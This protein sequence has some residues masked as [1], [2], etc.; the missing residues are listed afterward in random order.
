M[1]LQTTSKPGHRRPHRTTKMK[2]Q[3]AIQ[4]PKLALENAAPGTQ[5][6]DLVL[7]SHFAC[8]DCGISFEE[9]TPQ[10]FSFNSPQGMCTT[11]TAWAN[12][13]ASIRTTGRQHRPIV[14]AR[15]H[16]AGRHV[17]RFG[18]WKRHIFRGVAE[19]MERKLGLA[20]NSLLETPWSDLTPKQRASGSGAPATSTS[21]TLGVP[22]KP[23]KNMAARSKA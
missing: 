9:P 11:A 10:L 15:L 16:R 17:E 13:S 21:R 8:T 12:S 3:P 18:R 14:R 2:T 19:T 23:L 7:S 6:G 4:N 22:E 20:E 1:K 5:P